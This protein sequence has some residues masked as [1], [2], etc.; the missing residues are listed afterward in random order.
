MTNMTPPTIETNLNHYLGLCKDDVR[1]RIG[2]SFSK[3][4]IR[5]RSTLDPRFSKDGWTFGEL[6]FNSLILM[7]D[8]KW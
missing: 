8:I 4:D 6:K 3:S 7:H 5:G 1:G 2:I